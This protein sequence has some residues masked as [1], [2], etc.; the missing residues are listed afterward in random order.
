MGTPEHYVRCLYVT[1]PI[2]RTRSGPL[3]QK[4]GVSYAGINVLAVLMVSQTVLCLLLSKT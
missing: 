3:G 1:W 2:V 4:V